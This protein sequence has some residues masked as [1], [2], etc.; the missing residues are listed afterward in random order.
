MSLTF[1][2]PVIVIIIVAALIVKVASVALN[3]TGLD[4]KTSFFQAL[5][6]FTGTGFTTQD[7]EQVV[8]NDLRR[9]IIIAMMIIGNAGLVSVITSLVLTI[10]F[11]FKHGGALFIAGN[12][13]VIMIAVTALVFI[14]NNKWVRGVL[15]RHIKNSLGRTQT[16]TK[17]PVEEIFRLAKGYG[18]AEVTLGP[19]CA[20]AGKTLADS[21]LR[22]RDILILAIERADNVIPT[23]HAEDKLQ[24]GDTIICYGKLDNITAIMS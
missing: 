11:T 2:L 15:T 10:L 3:L 16:F 22:K 23:P 17:R 13:V 20:E 12:I 6:A 7:A 18:V 21:S 9:K 8:R 14:S 24:P 1:V 4:E 19:D 5:S